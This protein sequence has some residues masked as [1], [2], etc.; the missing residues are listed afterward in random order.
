M[1]RQSA[2]IFAVVQI[3]DLYLGIDAGYVA[4]ALPWPADLVAL[5]P[6]GG[7]IAGVFSHHGR[8][9]P[10]IDLRAWMGQPAEAHCPFALVLT[11]DT[12]TVAL[13]VTAVCGLLHVAPA[14]IEQVRHDDSDEALFCRVAHDRA[15]GR[16]LR[17]LEPERLMA[18]AQ[19][20]SRP[21]DA[22]QR[23]HA[24]DGPPDGAATIILAQFELNGA[25]LA[26]PAD[27]IAEVI[28]RP[29]VDSAFTWGGPL[30]GVAHW[31][32][33]QI[34]VLNDR[35]LGEALS[36]P[37]DAA[38][39]PGLLAILAA[40]ERYLGVPVDRVR[41]VRAV[42]RASLRGAVAGD[43][44]PELVA[45]TVLDGDCPALRVI[46]G[47]VLMGL[48]PTLAG[49]P[50]ADGQTLEQL[51]SEAYLVCAVG[52]EQALP[53]SAVVEVLTLPADLVRPASSAPRAAGS[54]IWRQNVLKVVEWGA[55]GQQAGRIVVID[56]G[57]AQLGLLVASVVTLVPAF[58]SVTLRYQQF[59]APQQTLVV[60]GD[61]RVSYQLRDL[62][63][64]CAEYA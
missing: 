8:P 59:G 11:Q 45:A 15:A 64:L 34:W 50:D 41:E 42:A 5:P 48:T 36:L 56:T 55:P 4:E 9:V 63:Q 2:T 53:L 21:A 52:N 46:D 61:K 40:G 60:L 7:S 39:P 32:G 17:L 22:G 58:Q 25:M 28:A 33:R 27:T 54:C 62:A 30:A 43:G 1:S 23:E 10:L 14:D 35:L 29:A 13:A 20:W 57:A 51:N 3:A 18:R 6:A 19:A 12:R 49:A 26:L 16:L 31:R 24:A 38:A 47:A 44:Q 37:R